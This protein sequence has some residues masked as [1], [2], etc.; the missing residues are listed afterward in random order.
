[1]GRYSGLTDEQLLILLKKGD[2]LAFAAIYERYWPLLLNHARRMLQDDDEA[3]DVLQDIFLKLWEQSPSLEFTS[4]F[5]GYLYT[6]VRNRILNRF[7]RDKVKAR[8]LASLSEF[9]E[10][11]EATTDFRIRERELARRIEEEVEHLPE[12][13]KAVFKLS[14]KQHLSYN[15]IADTLRISQNTVKK[16]IS[17]AIRELKLRLGIHQEW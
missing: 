12:K 8:Y 6:L 9:I 13:M 1:M 2:E 14:R 11:G 16:Q 10:K 17:N 4:S 3:Y 5:S 7:I 15:Q